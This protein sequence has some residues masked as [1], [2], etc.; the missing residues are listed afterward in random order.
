MAESLSNSLFGL[1]NKL[2][3]VLCPTASSSTPTVV[4]KLKKLNETVYEVCTPLSGARL[5]LEMIFFHGLQMSHDKEAYATTWM[6]YDNSE[7]WLLWLERTFPRARI[8]TISYDSSIKKTREHGRMD[9]YCAAE[10]LVSDLTSASVRVGK[11][12]C[13]IVLVG[14]CVGGLVLKELCLSA[15]WMLARQGDKMPGMQH[16]YRFFSNLRG[17]FFYG[18]PH[19]GSLLGEKLKECFKGRLVGEIETL[20]ASTARRN[21]E[22]RQLQTSRSWVT[23]AM[24]ELHETYVECIAEA[25]QVVPEASARSYMDNYYSVAAD[26]NKVCKPKSESCSAFTKLTDFLHQ[27]HQDGQLQLQST[28]DSTRDYFV[29]LD[30]R[31][32]R[33]QM[34]LAQPDVHTVFITG[35][36][37]IGKSR[38]AEQ[39]FHNMSRTF[40][41][42][43]IVHLDSVDRRSN[44]SEHALR[45]QVLDKLQ[46][47]LKRQDK[48][49]VLH[50]RFNV[51]HY[52]K[53]K[54]V[55]VILDNVELQCQLDALDRA[56]WLEGSG[57]RLL[58]TTSNSRLVSGSASK[59][60]EVPLLSWAESEILFRHFA[61]GDE[62]GPQSIRD[63][64]QQVIRKCEYFPLALKVMG[65]FLS[66]KKFQDRRLWTGPM[67]R[68][69][70]AKEVDG[71]ASLEYNIW[72]RLKACFNVLEPTEQETFLDAA[73]VFHGWPLNFVNEYIWS[74]SRDSLAWDNL[75]DLFLVSVSRSGEVRMHKL[76]RDMARSIACPPS[77]RPEKW[78][79]IPASAIK[80]ELIIDFK[81]VVETCSLDFKVEMNQRVQLGYMTSVQ[82]VNLEYL[83]LE[84]GVTIMGNVRLPKS[85]VYLRWHSGSFDDCP[86]DFNCAEKLI[87]LDLQDCAAM[88]SL[89]QSVV[90]AS[91]LVWLELK[92]CESLTELPSWIVTLCN[93]KHLGLRRTR[94]KELPSNLGKLTKLIELEVDGTR[95]KKIP[96]SIGHMK[97]LVSIDISFTKVKSLPL[98]IGDL[99]LLTDLSARDTELT[100]LPDSIGRLQNL[101]RLDLSGTGL[102]RLPDSLGDAYG[103]QHLRLRGA[104]LE[105]LP[106][107]ICNLT[108]LE[109][110]ELR[111]THLSS[112]P[113]G[114]GGLQSLCDLDLVGTRL[115]SLPDSLGDLG[116]LTELKLH[117]TPLETLPES[118]CNLSRLR[119]LSLSNTQISTLPQ[120][121]GELARLPYLD[122]QGCKV[123]SYR[124]SLR[125]L[126]GLIA[127]SQEAA[128]F[129]V[130]SEHFN[131]GTLSIRSD[132]QENVQLLQEH[133]STF[134]TDDVDGEENISG[135]EHAQATTL[136]CLPHLPPLCSVWFLELDGNGFKQSLLP[137]LFHA[138]QQ[139]SVSELHLRGFHEIESIPCELGTLAGMQCLTIRDCKNL[140]ELP[141]LVGQL[142]ELRWVYLRMLPRL[143]RLPEWIGTSNITLIDIEKCGSLRNLPS[144]LG[145]RS[146]SE[147]ES[148][149]PCNSGCMT[150]SSDTTQSEGFLRTDSWSILQCSLECC[151]SRFSK[152]RFKLQCKQMQRV[153]ETVLE[154]GGPVDTLS[155]RSFRKLCLE[156]HGEDDGLHNTFKPSSSW[157]PH[158]FSTTIS[159]YCGL[160]PYCKVSHEEVRVN[161]NAEEESDD[162]QEQEE[163]DGNQEEE[164]SD[165]EEDYSEQE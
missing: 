112:L 110:L 91:K 36:S 86:L 74:E 68:L 23:C 21:E 6:S 50:H 118:I 94:V 151:V 82:F 38:L 103:L 18:T 54:K 141:E 2:Q 84:G 132:G 13:P 64:V 116:G 115:T 122:L 30:G 144:S 69:D 5:E 133:S 39:I 85:L 92:G 120:A 45:Q 3:E 114:I 29:D 99:S 88:K 137:A 10:N 33:V 61:F 101:Q 155:I 145:H 35:L 59:T 87:V 106:D 22:F 161:D 98:C 165:E 97:M 154:E 9:M 129:V 27:I 140:R 20:K 126:T 56:G 164:E 150:S 26:H 119:Y 138:V 143:C 52:L 57:S 109:K 60:F 153:K 111:F 47:E 108:L 147:G 43:C 25:I 37:G 104:P 127:F 80:N 159:L 75:K 163:S 125:N 28:V 4:P 136:S 117:L 63:L 49:L 131:S 44:F 42:A 66:K 102:K 77:T 71:G 41:V 72:S 14:H 130:D 162:D 32:E 51:H 96:K 15:G 139:M 12:G 100:S 79:R 90:M 34:M 83:I 152:I 19:T 81:G 55:L 8:L 65:R 67:E 40:D 78:R 24:G 128:S 160:Y 107:S 7:F 135:E 17:M 70:N 124:E 149:P 58:V 121:F 156:W 142:V 62:D 146:V 157:P 89:P 105:M 134:P 148:S 158:P 73:L 76:L 53:E 95:L 93:L 1:W 123:G 11:V 48:E 31:A 16:V 46:D 113:E